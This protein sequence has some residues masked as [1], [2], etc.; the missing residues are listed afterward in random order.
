MTGWINNDVFLTKIDATGSI[1][2]GKLYGLIGA[3]GT[4]N[5][6]ASE[7][8]FATAD[9]G[10]IIAATTIPEQTA[11]LIKTDGQG[12][13]F[14][15]KIQGKIGYDE[16]NNCQVEQEENGVR[17]RL[18]KAES[19]DRTYYAVSDI[20]GNYE[21]SLPADTYTISVQTAGTYWENCQD[22]TARL[23]A[24][25]EN[26]TVDIA[27]QAAVQ[28]PLMSVDIQT[29][30]LRKCIANTYRVAFC[31]EGTLDANAAY[32]EIA[33]DEYLTID[34]ASVD[35]MQIGDQLFSF[36]IG[37]VALNECGAFKVHTTLSCS[38]AVTLGQ[39]HCV[40]AN[41]FP[42]SICTPTNPL[43]DGSEI[44]TKSRCEGD[45]LIFVIQNI[46]ESDMETPLQYIVIQDQIILRT[47]PFEL[48]ANDSIRLSFPADGRAYTVFSQQSNFLNTNAYPS[49]YIADCTNTTAYNNQLPTNDTE[50]TKSVFCLENVN[51]F[52]PNDK[53]AKI[54][55]IGNE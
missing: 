15:S 18:V 25:E 48:P 36:N 52:D 31:N 37:D 19:S 49:S 16:N 26:Q 8:I 34:S 28:C 20:Q 21:F 45:S 4:P 11:Y 54:Q 10:F 2:F 14:N 33:F 7:G 1:I 29:S 35:Y 43:W 38:D 9:G 44:I 27:L 12:N 5:L 6:E 24:T 55:G 23:G 40:T 3:N 39:N 22:Y 41:I 47:V 51:S 50:P 42:D 32:V 53:Q 13:V 46:G 30:R 17:N